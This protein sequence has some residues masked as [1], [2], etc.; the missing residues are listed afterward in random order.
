MFAVGVVG[1]ARAAQVVHT[2]TLIMAI[3]SLMRGWMTKITGDSA[4]GHMG[5]L[6]LLAVLQ[7]EHL[8]CI[9]VV[10]SLLLIS[11]TQLYG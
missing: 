10:E 2:S 3:T 8:Q 1:P 11:A 6:L 4:G 7:L 5:H 9:A